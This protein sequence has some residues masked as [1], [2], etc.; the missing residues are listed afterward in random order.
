MREHNGN[1][2]SKVLGELGE[3][4]LL[5]GRQSCRKEQFQFLKN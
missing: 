2:W 5:K 3:W 4:S 1:G